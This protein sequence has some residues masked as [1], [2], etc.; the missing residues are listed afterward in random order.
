MALKKLGPYRIGEPLGRG[1]MGTV[2]R[3]INEETDE[4]AAI[5]VLSSVLA[6]DE[7]FRT[8]FEAEIETL[9]T[10]KHPNIVQLYGYGEHEGHLFYAME[11]VEGTSLEEEIQN[12]RR[13]HW[14][15]TTHIG[16]EI[17]RAL[18]HAHDCGVIHRDLKP[19]N[20]L[21]DDNEHIKLTDFGIAKLFG[22]TQMTAMGGVL[23]TADY[24]APEQAEGQPVTPRSDLYS[25]GSVMYALL[26]GRPPFRG[27]TMGEVL[28]MLRYADP[29][30]VRNRAPD[31][32]AA[33]EKI[34]GQL[35]E[36]SPQKRIPTA[37]ALS[38]VLQATE[39]ALSL[40][41]QTEDDS[42]NSNL[43]SASTGSKVIQPTDET[44]VDVAAPID[45]KHPTLAD[46]GSD[47]KLSENNEQPEAPITTEN[48]FTTVHEGE[49]GRSHSEQRETTS[50][51]DQIT[52]ILKTLLSVTLIIGLM[53]GVW[54]VTRP[55][56]ADKLFD[57][58]QQAA[59][60]NSTTQLAKAES[61]IDDFK[62]RFPNDKRIAEL[63]RLQKQFLLDRHRIR[64]ELL[65]KSQLGWHSLTPV[66][67]AY[68]NVLRLTRPETKVTHLQ[69]FLNLYGNLEEPT[70][71]IRQCLLLAE[72][73]LKILR[74]ALDVVN[75]DG[76]HRLLE[77]ME[78]AEALKTKGNLRAAKGI[79][80]GIVQLYT[81]KPLAAN[82]VSQAQQQLDEIA[83]AKK[84]RDPP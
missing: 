40:P 70:Q 59:A 23:G 63:E 11:L 44:L 12:G 22:Y 45:S 28:H 15:E 5:K 32:P 36:K 42:N 65:A 52:A 81:D 61:N 57:S 19:A 55:P 3:G 35:L 49:L 68:V 21:L 79:W 76:L 26:S 1:G 66:E 24:M 60:A 29:K 14:R 58:I 72:H 37:L 54:Y 74:A 6:A 56:S 39:H 75:R 18:K 83:E 8:R 71:P 34:I 2:Y 25:V 82:V 17:C 43:P 41:R 47:R 10:L 73:E 27:K 46:S 69:A 30:P 84:T 77:R 53:A 7:A 80:N 4:A 78:M 62:R 38:N 16:I 9:K 51:G 33:L 50:L 31:V 13:F 20:L 67:L 48:H 64:L